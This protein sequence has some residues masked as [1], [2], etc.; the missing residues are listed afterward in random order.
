[1]GRL[2][3]YSDPTGRQ[4][5]QQQAEAYIQQIVQE[6]NRNADQLDS[7]QKSLSISNPGKATLSISGTSQ[8]T[9]VNVGS[10]APFSFMA[11]M[12]RSDQ[13]TNYWALP[14]VLTQGVPVSSLN[15]VAYANLVTSANG[16][17]LLFDVEVAAGYLASA[18]ALVTFYYFILNQPANALGL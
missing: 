18:P 15:M 5:P 6:L 1:M 14:Y 8:S 11:F 4:T 17:S 12:V 13:P 10:P 3:S 2:N 7:L 16:S 9:T